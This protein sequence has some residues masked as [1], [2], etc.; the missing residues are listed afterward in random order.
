M[1]TRNMTMVV[2]R[3]YAS[4]DNAGFA[5]DPWKLGDKSL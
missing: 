1:S 5:Q 4:D 2:E 3:D